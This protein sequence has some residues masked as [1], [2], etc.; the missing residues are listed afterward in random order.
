MKI[1]HLLAKS[2]QLSSGDLPISTDSAMVI[3]NRALNITYF[4][5]GVVAIIV[6][7]L[8]GYTFTTAVYDTAKITQAKNALIY[9]IVGLIVVIF[10]WTI[11]QFIMGKF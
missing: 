2:A 7:I 8:A 9:S 5:A 11:T 1:L 10:A 4:V 3:L 6:I